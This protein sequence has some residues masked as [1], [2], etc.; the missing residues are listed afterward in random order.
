[1]IPIFLTVLVVSAVAASSILNGWVLSI[2]WGW[3]FVPILGLPA[4]NV[5]QSIGIAL[6]VGYLTHQRRTAADSSDRR[7]EAFQTF[8][9]AF[10]NP[11]VALLIG[12]IVKGFM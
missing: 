6:I 3:F 7:E 1:M 2:M 11:L 10:L 4:L 8:G 5:P 12:W 9:Y